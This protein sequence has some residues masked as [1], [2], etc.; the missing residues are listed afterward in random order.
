M[1]ELLYYLSKCCWRLAIQSMA[2]LF[3]NAKLR[4]FQQLVKLIGSF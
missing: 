1:Q 3:Y 2:A 4:I